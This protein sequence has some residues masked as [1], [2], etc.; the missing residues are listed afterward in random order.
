MSTIEALTRR[1]GEIED[2]LAALPADAFNERI[3]LHEEERELRTE[4]RHAGHELF[5]ED[6]TEM[7]RLQIADLERRIEAARGVRLS[8]SAAAQTGRGGGIDPEH[9]H[10]IN[11]A[12][13]RSSGVG[14]LQAELHRL[15]VRLAELDGT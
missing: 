10:A 14:G 6:E 7:L 3:T 1:I 15:R 5:G 13:D 11:A 12:L 9:V 4:L 8:A 2:R